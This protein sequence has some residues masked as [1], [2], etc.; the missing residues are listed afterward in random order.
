MKID[1]TL[2]N[3]KLVTYKAR[4]LSLNVSDK[5]DVRWLNKHSAIQS[6][7]FIMHEEILKVKK[8]IGLLR[9]N[10]EEFGKKISACTWFI[11][12]IEKH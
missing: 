1:T 8:L 3:T 4:K 11:L 2:I 6:C 9:T 10:Q 7:I 5:T 12:I